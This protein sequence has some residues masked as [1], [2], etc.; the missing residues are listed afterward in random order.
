MHRT[1]PSNGARCSIAGRISRPRRAQHD[2]NL[3][4]RLARWPE[5]LGDTRDTH[6]R[7]VTTSPDRERNRL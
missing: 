2:V 6:A 1:A 4:E 5:G 7:G 3:S